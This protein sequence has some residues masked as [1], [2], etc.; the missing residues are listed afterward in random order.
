MRENEREREKKKKKNCEEEGNVSF[1]A[2]ANFHITKARSRHLERK[3][4]ERKKKREKQTNKTMIQRRHV[5]HQRHS[6]CCL[7]S[8]S[9]FH[10][11]AAVCFEPHLLSLPPSFCVFV[12]EVIVLRVFFLFFFFCFFLLLLFLFLILLAFSCCMPCLFVVSVFCLG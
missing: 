4:N 6:T 11:P 1:P 5:T 9:I 12:P 2:H 7:S 10:L 8:S 3:E